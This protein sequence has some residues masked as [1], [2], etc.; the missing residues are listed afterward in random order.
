[1]EEENG[2]ANP[3]T[4]AERAPDSVPDL[5]KFKSVEALARA[6]RELEAEFTRRSQRLK[7]LEEKAEPSAPQESGTDGESERA[8][9]EDES[10]YRAVTNNEGVR[11]RV[12]SEYLETLKG[13]PLMT[14]GGAGVTAPVQ[15]PKS[16]REAGSLALGYL[17]NQKK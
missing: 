17:R 11:A 15:K 4:D 13:V 10:L 16:V 12:L 8:A 2:K 7:A 5:G 3:G 9:R 14:G 6:Y 1:M